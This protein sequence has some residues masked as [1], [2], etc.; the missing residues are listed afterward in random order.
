MEREWLSVSDTYIS[1]DWVDGYR[2]INM[3]IWTYK[4][5]M[6]TLEGSWISFC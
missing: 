3:N 1:N 2:D 6:Y 5:Y 4:L